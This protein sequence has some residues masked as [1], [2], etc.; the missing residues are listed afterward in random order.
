MYCA[1]R[2]DYLGHPSRFFFGALFCARR[3]LPRL[4]HG[5]A[6]IPLLESID[7]KTEG[8]FAGLRD[9]VHDGAGILARL[10]QGRQRRCGIAL[11]R[12]LQRAHQSPPSSLFPSSLPLLTLSSTIAGP[13][14]ILQVLLHLLHVRRLPRRSHHDPL[15][16]PV[17][18]R[19][20]Q[21]RRHLVHE[22]GVD[23]VVDGRAGDHYLV[24]PLRFIL[25]GRGREADVKVAG[26]RT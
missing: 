19:V 9:T 1:Q 8:W 23:G 22:L 15:A 2:L 17:R 25:S 16:R 13:F 5:R 24:R 3:H 7:R 26:T 18:E 20:H 12:T 14:P 6:C 4:A 11:P 21:H 10:G